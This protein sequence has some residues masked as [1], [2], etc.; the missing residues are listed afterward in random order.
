MYTMIKKKYAHLIQKIIICCVGYWEGAKA[1]AEMPVFLTCSLLATKEHLNFF[2]RSLI[3][4]CLRARSVLGSFGRKFVKVWD[5][6]N[7]RKT[8]PSFRNIRKEGGE[9]LR[10]RINDIEK[11]ER[12]NSKQTLEVENKEYLQYNT[13]NIG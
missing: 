10:V 4:S 13:L 3:F 8:V 11:R 6:G 9:W 2:N 7:S 12:E 1:L 5:R